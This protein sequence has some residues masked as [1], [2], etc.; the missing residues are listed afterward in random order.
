MSGT[1]TAYEAYLLALGRGEAP[2]Q[3]APQTPPLG[4]STSTQGPRADDSLESKVGA[5]V[6][7]PLREH[8]RQRQADGLRLREAIRR[9]VDGS[10]KRLNAREVTARLDPA[11]LGRGERPNVRTVQRHLKII[12]THV[13][14]SR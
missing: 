13:G 2:P 9:V 3:T 14:V 5:R 10:T 4:G 12:A 8:N 11:S 1:P 7:R 6:L